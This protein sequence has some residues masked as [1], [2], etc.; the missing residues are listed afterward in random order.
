MTTMKT[1]LLAAAFAAA[2]ALLPAAEASARGG[3]RGG[4]FRSAPSMRSFRSQRSLG[5]PRA[6]G[7]GSATRPSLDGPES[8]SRIGG[9][10]GNRASASTRRGLYDSARRNGTLFSSR[11]EAAQSFKSRYAKDYGSAFAAEPATRP[12][13]IP[14]S[15]I[16]GGR[17]V[18]VVYNSGLGGYGYIH[19]VLG[20]WML[21]DAL[22][23]AAML[24]Y[25]MSNRGY[26][27]GGAPAYVS[28]GPSFMSFAFGILVLFLVVS[29][30]AR[31]AARRRASRDY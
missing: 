21:F 30:L 5:A 28:H 4:G 26:Y 18:N 29:F 17:N 14:S 27:W 7:W 31:A 13:Y 25:A 24:D 2:L 1:R 16:V 15:A 19:P 10:S 22:G 11:D 9:I 6:S 23:D 20:T 8:T 12:S 3:F